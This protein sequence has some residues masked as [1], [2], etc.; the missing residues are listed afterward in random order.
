ME[1]Q[2]FDILYLV[3][4]IWKELTEYNYVLTYGYKKQ[5]Y[6]I[7]LTFSPEDFPHLAGFQYL[8]DLPLPRYYSHKIV[9]QILNH[10]LTFEQIIKGE[11]Y[12]DFVKP[13]LEA[14]AQLKNIIEKDFSLYSYMPQMYPFVT[15]IKADYL[16]SSNDIDKKFIFI[17]KN[18]SDD[19]VKNAYLCC[20]AFVEDKR[21]YESN[22]R[23]RTILRKERI[24]ISSQER[25][26]LYD[27]LTENK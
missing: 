4:T 5:L 1:E 10:K 18:D 21:D 9:N 14:L 22:Q 26:I 27:R 12:E 25:T 8:R 6:T 15:T 19:N 11:K 7:N 3:A 20:S 23:I 2:N 17:I 13:R 24:H 16:I